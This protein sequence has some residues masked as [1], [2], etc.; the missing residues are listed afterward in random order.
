MTRIQKTTS[1]SSS[2]SPVS[3]SSGLKGYFKPSFRADI[4][5]RIA[6][7]RVRVNDFMMSETVVTQKLWVT[8]MGERQAFLLSTRKDDLCVGDN[9]PMF[10]FVEWDTVQV[11]LKRLNELTGLS[12]RFPTEAEWEYA[13]RGGRRSK[14]YIYAG[15]NHIDEVAWYSDSLLHEVALKAPNELGLYDMT[16][17][18]LEICSDYYDDSY[19]S[20][21]PFDNPQGPNAYKYKEISEQ[22]LGPA[23]VLR[24]GFYNLPASLCR[25]SCRFS[26][27]REGTKGTGV[28]S[29]YAI[30]LVLDW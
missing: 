19:Y 4:T 8:V 13:A 26:G 23:H 14:G 17:N 21:S 11:F 6:L 18:C 7:H 30:R 3:N 27:G 10:L 2:I 29:R 9:Y 5:E 16:G 22:E 28:T 12:F 15:S 24:G 25:I 1:E 20:I